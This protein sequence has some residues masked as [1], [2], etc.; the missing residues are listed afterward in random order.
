MTKGESQVSASF[1]LMKTKGPRFLLL[2]RNVFHASRMC[3]CRSFPRMMAPCLACETGDS[4]LSGARV[5]RIQD[6]EIPWETA[7]GVKK[8][9]PVKN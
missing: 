7:T 1:S 9:G 6:L 4:G 2:W 5:R 3:W 8:T